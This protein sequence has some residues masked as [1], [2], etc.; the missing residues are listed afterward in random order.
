M[1]VLSSRVDRENEIESPEFHES[2][3]VVWE[4]DLKLENDVV[5]GLQV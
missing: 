4:R 3:G 2:K 5:S 1:R